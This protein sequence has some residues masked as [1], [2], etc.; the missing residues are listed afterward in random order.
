MGLGGILCDIR[1]LEVRATPTGQSDV[2]Y[3]IFTPPRHSGSLGVSPDFC[4]EVPILRHTSQPVTQGL[5]GPRGFLSQADPQTKQC[6]LILDLL[7]CGQDL[8][9]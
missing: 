9:L 1:A 2:L 7:G 6:L 3:V 4:P 5:P 8:Y